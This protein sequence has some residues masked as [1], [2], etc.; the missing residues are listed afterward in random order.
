MEALKVL[1]LVRQKEQ[2]NSEAKY[3]D[4]DIQGAVNE[5]LRYL[6]ISLANKGNEYLQ[7]IEVYDQNLINAQIA[8]ENE[9]NAEDEEY[10][11]KDLVDF[12]ETGVA[13]PE[14]YISLVDVQRTSDGY[15]LHPA[16]SL[17]EVRS[18]DGYG[19]YIIMGDKIF[20]KG[21]AFQLCYYRVIPPVKDFKEDKIDLP[22]ICL[23][24][25]VKL[26]RLVL[27]NADVDTMTQAVNT[28]VERI[29]PRR[30]YANSRQKMPFSL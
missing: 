9:E 23:D 28:A 20:I 26:T 22:D 12:A 24:P 11:P 5:T 13:L 27:N 4:Y 21:K 1:R 3:S 18:E 30:R 2:D 6:N 10:I 25:V 29:M 19:K 8:A 16:S 15:H 17:F 7:K 14:D